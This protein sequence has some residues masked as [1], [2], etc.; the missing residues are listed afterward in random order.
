MNLE[1]IEHVLHGDAV[2]LVFTDPPRCSIH[3]DGFDGFLGQVCNRLMAVCEGA[4]Y[5]CTSSLDQ[6]ALYRAFCEAGGQWSTFLI[7]AKPHFN[8]GSSDYQQQ[9]EL[10][11]YGWPKGAKRFWC[12]DATQSDVWS[13]L[14]PFSEDGV[15]TRKPVE[16]VERALDNSSRPGDIVFDLFAGLGTT[17]IACERRSR[18]ARLIEIDPQQVDLICR[19]W[20]QFT[21]KA[22]VLESNSHTF[23]Q[24]AA[25][26]RENRLSSRLEPNICATLPKKFELWNPRR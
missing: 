12:G 11:L 26:R 15:S 19:R 17:L 1:A 10:I 25:E 3:G 13:F 18:Q 16:L 4:I 23:E 20:E 21:G 14:P 7:W 9:Y 2:Q 8:Q 22:G 5:V 6:H 24:V